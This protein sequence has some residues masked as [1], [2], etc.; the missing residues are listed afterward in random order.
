MIVSRTSAGRKNH[1]GKGNGLDIVARRSW[2]APFPSGLFRRIDS[3]RCRWKPVP[4]DELLSVE[5]ADESDARCNT[6]H[7]LCIGLDGQHAAGAVG[8]R[9]AT[10]ASLD[11]IHSGFL[12]RVRHAQRIASWA[13]SCDR[14]TVIEDEGF[15]RLTADTYLDD[16][17]NATES[18]PT[19]N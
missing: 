3:I 5:R 18:S 16:P 12:V 6:E 2:I 15:A 10:H 17:N 13:G 9:A 11:D 8:I 1:S 4:V 19:R 14:D 7:D